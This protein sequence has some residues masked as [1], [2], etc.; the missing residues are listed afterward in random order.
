MKV[1]ISSLSQI[2]YLLRDTQ[3]SFAQYN[4]KILGGGRLPEMMLVEPNSVKR[5]AG[6]L[7]MP[8]VGDNKKQIKLGYQRLLEGLSSEVRGSPPSPLTYATRR[9]PPRMPTTVA[10]SYAYES[11]YD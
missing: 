7:E 9:A 1:V 6:S 2:R 8:G 3:G 4:N 11:T 10:P 5:N